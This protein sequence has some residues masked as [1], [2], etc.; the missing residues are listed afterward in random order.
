ME[1]VKFTYKDAEYVG[2][3]IN[4]GKNWVEVE[5]HPGVTMIVDNNQLI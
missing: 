4:H 5:I 3:V 1:R 2:K